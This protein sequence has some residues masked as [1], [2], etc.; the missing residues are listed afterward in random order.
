M[1]H[2]EQCQHFCYPFPPNLHILSVRGDIPH[3]ILVNGHSY[4][5]WR[6]LCWDQRWLER[7]C[8]NILYIGCFGLLGYMIK[9]K[10]PEQQHAA[11]FLSL[12]PKCRARKH[13]TMYFNKVSPVKSMINGPSRKGGGESNPYPEH[14]AQFHENWWKPSKWNRHESQPRCSSQFRVGS[15]A[16][17]NN[18][19][20]AKSAPRQRSLRA[21]NISFYG[22][23]S[24]PPQTWLL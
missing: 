22:C 3:C 1:C 6:C 24:K 21:W 12:K 20:R 15:Q 16:L 9:V 2:F 7:T 5:T 23:H 10:S 8:W 17:N 4:L 13:G 14:F 18:D 19:Y 11:W